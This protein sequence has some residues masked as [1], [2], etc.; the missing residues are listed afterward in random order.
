[1]KETRPYVSRARADAKARTRERIL[2]AVVE[3]AE[4][5]FDLDPKLDEIA[6]RAGVSVQTILR[7]FG[8]RDGLF[9]AALELGK[10]AYTD[11]REVPVGDVGAAAR[12]IVAHYEQRG[13]FVIRM[14]G[15]EHD[16]L[17]VQQITEPGK[18]SHRQWVTDVFAPLLATAPAAREAQLDL[19]V[20]ATDVYTWKLLRRDRGLSSGAVASRIEQ[21]A[22]A[23][24]TTEGGAA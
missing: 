10:G 8:S 19:L 18:A 14:L 12:T 21:L 2:R 22:T 5:T 15:R 3:H 17:R 23:V 16:D 7:H 6:A 11:E 1:M 13:D 4:E 9:D 20:V 24:L